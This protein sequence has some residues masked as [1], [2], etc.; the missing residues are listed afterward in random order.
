MSTGKRPRDKVHS[1]LRRHGNDAHESSGCQIPGPFRPPDDAFG[2]HDGGNHAGCYQ[3][4]THLLASM[5]A[6]LSRCQQTNA[7]AESKASTSYKSDF[8]NLKR[9]SFTA[10]IASC[11][12]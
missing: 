12:E 7:H 6:H 8:R 1:A 11:A 3:T 10:H 2:N 9:N 4:P 5:A